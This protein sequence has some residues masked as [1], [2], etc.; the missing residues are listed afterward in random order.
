MKRL[1]KVVFFTGNRSEF[2]LMA[3]IIKRID[4]DPD[5]EFKLIVT[6][7]HMEEEFGASIE[8]I[9]KENVNIDYKV[10][11]GSTGK[12]NIGVLDEVSK[13][14]KEVGNILEIEKP[15]YFFVLGD[16]YETFAAAQAAFFSNIPIVHSGGGN[17]T[18]GGCLDDTLRHLI[19]KMASLHFVTCKENMENVKKLGEE[20]WRIF[21]TGSPAVETVL[22]EGLIS[23]EELESMFNISLDK[24]LIMFT[25]HPVASS[26]QHS[27]SQVRESLKALSMLGFQTIITYPNTDAGGSLIIE[28]YKKW[29]HVKNFIFIKSL[30]RIKYLSLMKYSSV[31]V[32][33]SSS[34]LLETPIFKIPAVNI[35]ER[36]K[37]HSFQHRAF[38]FY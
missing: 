5:M 34:G 18:L 17:I 35:G 12:S 25:Q 3:P 26:W 22:N 20:H 37:G 19:T 15:D 8:E 36:Q 32:G 13:I 11:I 38:F 2:S 27:D 30:G 7:A 21:E 9:E 28:E 1:M 29:N 23:K 33:N 10:N 6:G 14:F 16:R 24:P 4:K 31:V